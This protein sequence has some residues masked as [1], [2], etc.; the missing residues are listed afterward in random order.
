[1]KDENSV[2]DPLEVEPCSRVVISTNRAD[3]IKISSYDRR[4]FIPTF[5][6]EKKRNIEEAF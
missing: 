1:M 2:I 6:D 4:Y 3:K 5:S